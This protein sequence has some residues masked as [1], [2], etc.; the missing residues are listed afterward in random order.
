M[1]VYYYIRHMLLTTEKTKP[2]TK[3]N[4]IVVFETINL[5]DWIQY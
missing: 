3:K 1:A 5:V 4:Q 2:K